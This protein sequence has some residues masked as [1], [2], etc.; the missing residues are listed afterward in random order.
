MTVTA[1]GVADIIVDSVDSDDSVVVTVSCASSDE[2]GD[3]MF[4]V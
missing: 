1:T 3:N 4:A 2:R